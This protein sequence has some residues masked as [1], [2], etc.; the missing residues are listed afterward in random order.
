MLKGIAGAIGDHSIQQRVDLDDD[1]TNEYIF[2]TSLKKQTQQHTHQTG[3]HVYEF[4]VASWITLNAALYCKIA[5]DFRQ[6]YAFGQAIPKQE[7]IG[8]TAIP[9]KAPN[10]WRFEKTAGLSKL[11]FCLPGQ[12]AD[13]LADCL[14]ERTL[15]NQAALN[16]LFSRAFADLLKVCQ[17]LDEAIQLTKIVDQTKECKNPKLHTEEALLSLVLKGISREEAHL[18]IHK[19]WKK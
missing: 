16:Q 13:I 2:N 8:S 12:V 18:R 7:D 10:P 19:Q 17:T 4:E 5:N 1:K 11:L 14:L 15:T 3:D 6:M 9:G